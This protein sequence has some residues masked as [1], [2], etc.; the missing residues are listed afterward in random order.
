M[1]VEN[2]NHPAFLRNVFKGALVT[3][4]IGAL[5][6]SAVLGAASNKESSNN[7]NFILDNAGALADN[8]YFVDTDRNLFINITGND[9]PGIFIGL[10]RIWRYIASSLPPG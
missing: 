4:P 3:T 7:F 1:S 10:V 8:I 9:S 5:A 6:I 2:K